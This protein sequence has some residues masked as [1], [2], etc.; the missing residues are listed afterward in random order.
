MELLIRAQPLHGRNDWKVS[1]KLFCCRSGE[2]SRRKRIW[3]HERIDSS[4][5]TER[6]GERLPPDGFFK[7]TRR[8]I[9][10]RACI[11]AAATATAAAA[12]RVIVKF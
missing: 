6:R 11:G 4:S 5:L 1:S 9:V 8:Y 3:S 7:D 10:G 12:L 2:R